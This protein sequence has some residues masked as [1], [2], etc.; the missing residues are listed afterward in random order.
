MILSDNAKA[1]GLGDFFK[2]LDKRQLNASKKMV[3]KVSQNPGRALESGENVAT[4]FA[5]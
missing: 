4:A 2:N 3:K 1:A 5:S